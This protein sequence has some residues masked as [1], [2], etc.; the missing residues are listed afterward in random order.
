MSEAD[1][2]AWLGREPRWARVAGILALLGVALF[3]ASIV[4]QQVGGSADA[5]SDAERLLDF[6]EN[7]GRLL[8]AEIVGG[9]GF[10]LFG[11]PLYVLFRSAE[12]RA[13]RVRRALVAFAFIGPV[14]LGVQGVLLSAG[15]SDVADRFVEREAGAE[16]VALN[17]LRAR[18]GREPEAIDRIT[19][20]SDQDALDVEPRAGAPFSVDYRPSVEDSLRTDFEREGIDV[21]TDEDGMPGDALAEDLVDDS[22]TVETA[23]ALIFPGLLGLVI[24]LVYIP[25]WAMRTGLMTRFWATLGMALGVSLILLPF[26]QLAVVLWFVALAVLLLDWWPGGRPAA[27]EAGVAVPWPKPG[28]EA[29]ETR[30]TVEGRGRE[31]EEAGLPPDEERPPGPPTGQGPDAEPPQPSGPPPRKRKRRR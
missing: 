7:S 31:L 14:L 4:I 15:L 25:L 9:I 16:Q 21:D 10:A 23:T 18:V 30:D 22:G 24:G 3:I 26:A 6:D 1:R 8:L 12:A 19:F 5:D 11:A 17:E 28:E 2:R 29:A 13:E 20:Y 27:W